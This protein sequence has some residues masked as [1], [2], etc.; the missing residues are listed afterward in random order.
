MIEELIIGDRPNIDLQ[1]LRA[2]NQLKS[3]NKMTTMR[4]M[5]EAFSKSNFFTTPILKNRME[6]LKL[7]L[8]TYHDAKIVQL[9]QTGDFH[10]KESD[11]HVIFS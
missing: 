9:L 7:A 6:L 1:F 4:S 5:S 2:I 10:I 3:K 11:K 8:K